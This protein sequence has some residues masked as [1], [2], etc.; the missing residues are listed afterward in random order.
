MGF[1][2]KSSP[3]SGGTG[4]PVP[5]LANVDDGERSGSLANL[6][7]RSRGR[8]L[9][10]GRAVGHNGAMQVSVVATVYNEQKSIG[11]LLA[12]LAEQTRLPDEVVIC[13]GG[14]TDETVRLIREWAEAQGG[15]L[16]EVK[17]FVEPGANISRGRNAAIACA[18]GPLIAVTDAGVRLDKDWLKNLTAPWDGAPQDAA[19]PLAAAGFF[20]PDCRGVFETAMAATVLPLV[21]DIDPERFLPSSRSVAFLKSAWSAAGGYPEW[22]DYCEDLIFDFRLNALAAEGNSAF[23]W[24]PDALAHFRPRSSLRSFWLQYYRYA[25]GDGKADLWRK[26]HAIRYAVY[27][28][29]LPILGMLLW[30]GGVARLFG[31]A[32]LLAGTV[33]YFGRPWQR[34][35][36]LST[37]LTR[38]ERW[39]SYLL[40][41]LIRLVGDLAKMAGYPPGLLWR[42][43]NRAR[44]EIYWRRLLGK[45][46]AL[47]D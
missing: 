5:D 21:D 15:C 20:V 38:A 37:R 27:L 13:D 39:A 43:R 42:W 45:T 44:K 30:K 16:G 41:P 40:P 36:A 18:A 24:R 7:V 19:E 11:R 46:D 22:L 23:V 10:F 31:L 32:G 2:G 33:A 9:V 29:G 17:V 3:I 28:V 1:G 12:S 4:G 34:L 8:N 6:Q 25:R 26:R 35:H 14:S 47:T